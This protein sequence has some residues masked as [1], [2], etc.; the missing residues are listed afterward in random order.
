MT[1]PKE[2]PIYDSAG[3]PVGSRPVP[4]I[5]TLTLDAEAIALLDNFVPGYRNAA[6]LGVKIYQLYTSQI[7]QARE[8]L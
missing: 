3:V 5:A 2:E 7:T 4:T 1:T 8:G 6:T